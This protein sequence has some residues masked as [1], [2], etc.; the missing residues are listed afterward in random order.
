MKLFKDECDH[1]G[2]KTHI[3]NFKSR[4]PFEKRKLYLSIFT[5]DESTNDQSHE[6]INQEDMVTQTH[7]MEQFDY[8]KKFVF[9]VKFEDEF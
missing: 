6:N 1:N 5:F 7:H 3:G 8:D 9:Q 4:V 2:E